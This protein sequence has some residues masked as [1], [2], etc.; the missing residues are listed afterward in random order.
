M[1]TIELRQA[2][3]TA[4][5]LPLLFYSVGYLLNL[6]ANINA[7]WMQHPAAKWALGLVVPLFV[8]IA[9]AP[10]VVRRFLPVSPTPVARQFEAG[11]CQGLVVLVSKGDGVATARAAIEHHAATLERI[12]LI[13]SGLS[14]GDADSLIS[15]LSRDPRFAAGQFTKIAL[16]DTAF[17]DPEAVRSVIEAKIFAALPKGMPP[18]EVIVNI[19]GGT[20][21]TT[22][23]A[24]LAG[25]QPGRRLEVV[26]ALSRDARERGVTPGKPQEWRI[27]YSLR[28]VR[29]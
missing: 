18:E 8:L 3:I 23:G 20:K 19:M 4:D 6:S 26:P 12:W 16:S 7:A 25:M 13:H 9:L 2:L 24:F 11:S 1:E 28:R 27:N 21:Q 5:K 29:A 14:L 22:A 15:D 10:P 17:V